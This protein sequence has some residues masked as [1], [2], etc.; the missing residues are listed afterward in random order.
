MTTD[1]YRDRVMGSLLGGAIGDA[2]GAPVEFWSREQIVATVGHDGVRDY[3]ETSFGDVQGRG[4]ITDDTQMTLFTMEGL[5]AA[6]NRGRARGIGFVM[7]LVHEAY[8]RWYATQTTHQ[9]TSE[10]TSGLAS[11]TWLYSRRAPGI[12]C[13]SALQIVAEDASPRP[14]LLGQQAENDSKGCG[15]VM[16]AAPFGWIPCDRSDL[17]YWIV[18]STLE[19]AGYTHGHP[20]GQVSAAALALLIYELIFDGD[21]ETA[22][23]AA[24]D[25]VEP[26]P[27]STETVLALRQVLAVTHDSPADPA[28]LATFGEGWTG[29]EALAIAVYAALSFP[30]PDQVLDALALAV[31]HSGDSDSTGA[32]C[33]NILGALH[34]EGALPPHLIADLEGLPSIRTLGE[35]F[36]DTFTDLYERVAPSPRPPHKK[37]NP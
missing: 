14:A 8:L 6:Y 11:E 25:R 33:G 19:V 2:L 22:T 29:E 20:T 28:T 15:G 32:I 4:L 12:T 5:L 1:T 37:E 23:R 7:Q 34:G 18:P 26:L 17:D 36:I 24:I 21:L 16:R 13:L 10:H 35:E 30:E 31:S 27:G 3:L 9:P